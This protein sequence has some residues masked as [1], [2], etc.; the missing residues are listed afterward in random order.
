MPI[1]FHKD[2]GK[3]LANKKKKRLFSNIKSKFMN[4]R[5]VLAHKTTDK[6]GKLKGLTSKLGKTKNKKEQPKKQ[7]T[8]EQIKDLVE[9][10]AIKREPKEIKLPEKEGDG[11]KEVKIASLEEKQKDITNLQE[12]RSKIK[13]KLIQLQ[14]K[15]K[16]EKGRLVKFNQEKEQREKI[17]SKQEKIK[18]QELEEEIKILKEKEKIEEDRLAELRNA[19]RKE[20]I[21]ALR[22]RVT[23]ILFKKKPKLKHKEVIESVKEEVKEKQVTDTK[24]IEKPKGSK[25]KEIQK[26]K[27]EI[28]KTEEK[29]PKK[30]F[31]S[32][33]IQIKTAEEIAKEEKEKLKKEQE[34]ALK[35]NE[36]I[37]KMFQQEG[38]KTQTNIPEEQA[39]N[40]SNLFPEKDPKQEG[41]DESDT[42]ELDQGYKIKVVKNE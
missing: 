8:P 20:Q 2:M 38:V 12:K 22:G 7:I 11:W 25:T 9:K 15:E 5:A 18:R 1:D 27:E 23:D 29:K 21:Q 30:S 4:R 32:N 34:Q 40:F 16:T 42:I 39:V 28:K 26:K 13:E 31:F 3:Y 24:K 41:K 35:D 6:F 33:F 36:A 10:G 19:R 37:S 14:Q 17:E